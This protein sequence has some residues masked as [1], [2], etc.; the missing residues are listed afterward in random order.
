MT[1]TKSGI[2]LAGKRVTKKRINKVN[3]SGR[4]RF[5]FLGNVQAGVR[6]ISY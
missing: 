2:Q 5:D 6:A 3:A 1:Y 4:C